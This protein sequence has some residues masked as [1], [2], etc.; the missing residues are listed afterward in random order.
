MAYFANLA[1]DAPNMLS[2]GT[3]G[4]A[5][6]RQFIYRFSDV[7]YEPVFYYSG[8]P[9]TGEGLEMDVVPFEST[10]VIEFRYY[11][12]PI[13]IGARV[14]IGLQN[15]LTGTVYQNIAIF[16]NS[17][18][19]RMYADRITGNTVRYIPTFSP[20]VVVRGDPQFVGLRG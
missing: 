7:F 9:R 20:P 19:D 6:R 18:I 15:N 10:N 17:F 14:T 12:V 4:T 13:D 16:G 11:R 8:P 3:I 5:P 2:F 1:P